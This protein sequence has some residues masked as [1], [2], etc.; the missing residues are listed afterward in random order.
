M[1]KPLLAL[2]VLA[3]LIFGLNAFGPVVLEDGDTITVQPRT[4][5]QP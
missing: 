4:T 2:L 1:K 3:A 5:Q